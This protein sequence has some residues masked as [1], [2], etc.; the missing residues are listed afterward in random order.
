MPQIHE[1]PTAGALAGTEDVL[2]EQG[3]VVV[4]G[5][6]QQVVTLGVG[7]WIDLGSIGV[8]ATVTGDALLS[9]WIDLGNL[10]SSTVVLAG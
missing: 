6:V 1:L 8:T 7:A 5:Q 9:A 10:G 4:K 2:M 3:G